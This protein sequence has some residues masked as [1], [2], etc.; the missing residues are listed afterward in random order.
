M[1]ADTSLRGQR[2]PRGL[3]LSTG[4][5]VP[6]GQ[7]LRARMLVIEVGPRD[8]DAGILT[9]CQADA[10]AGSYNAS[11]AGFVRWIAGRRDEILAGLRDEV[12][13]C[14]AAAQ[15]SR[16]HRRTPDVV[17]NLAVGIERFLEFAEDIEAITAEERSTLSRR[18][19]AALGEAAAAQG[20]HQA[21]GEPA[22]RFL[23]LL[24]S[25]IA[26]GR[27][28]VAAEDGGA[29]AQ[30]GAWGWRRDEPDRDLFIR[31][32]WRPGRDRVGWL[33]EDGTDLYLDPD[34]SLAAAQSVGRDIGDPLTVQPRT[35]HKRLHEAGML[36]STE[37]ARGRL[38]IRRVLDGLRRAVLHLDAS[39]LHGAAQPAQPAHGAFD[40]AQDGPFPW[41]V[42]V[43]DGP[44]TAHEPDAGMPHAEDDAQDRGTDG[45]VGT[46]AARGEE[47]KRRDA[48][49]TRASAVGASSP[50]SAQQP[51]GLA[52]D[53]PVDAG[54]P[55]SDD[56]GT[57]G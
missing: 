38:A 49:A 27:A 11:L 2:P 52:V 28:H 26:S 3:V 37:G 36:R 57:V 50:A 9:A 40:D 53:I 42:R 55:L 1:R 23:E 35:L 44:P 21:S 14:R 19:W 51:L 8:V 56:W 25:A 18:C 6:R 33:G 10:A 45:T 46:V 47:P 32:R 4:E 17:A 12:V 7:S 54:R 13:R 16:A 34:A 22:T 31:E 5:D 48:R 24:A 39:L 41:A 30:P 20:E 43:S 15:A 29:P